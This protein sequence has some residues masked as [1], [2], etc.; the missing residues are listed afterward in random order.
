MGSVTPWNPSAAYQFLKNLGLIKSDHLATIEAVIEWGTIH[1]R[2]V[3]NTDPRWGTEEYLQLRGLADG[4]PLL[5]R[6]LYP[7]E[8]FDHVVLGCGGG[9]GLYASLL[10]VINIPVES[11]QALGWSGNH[12]R[13]SFASVDLSMPHADDIF[14]P[15]F[16]N[17]LAASGP[18][19]HIFY[20]GAEMDALF[21]NPA[22]DCNGSVCNTVGEQANHNHWRTIRQRC[23]DTLCDWLVSDYIDF[24]PDHVRNISLGSPTAGGQPLEFAFPLFTTAEKDTIVA[25]IEAY[26][27]LLGSGDIEFGKTEYNLRGAHPN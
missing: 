2:H 14:N 8:G 6:I 15:F 9:N 17:G 22:L 25:D 21:L 3:G 5:D 20:T 18:V 13:P 11:A 1:T 4:W 7:V 26:L 23:A 24:G 12:F 19:S 16:G 10:R 27:T